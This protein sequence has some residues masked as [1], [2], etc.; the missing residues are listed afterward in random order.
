MKPKLC[1]ETT[2]PS[3]LTSRPSR[4]LIVAGHQQITREWW[5]RQ[6]DEF[7]I[8]LSQL[9]MDEASAGDAEAARERWNAISDFPLLDIPQEVEALATIILASGRATL[10]G[11]AV[12]G[13]RFCELLERRPAPG[14]ARVPRAKVCMAT[15]RGLATG[16]CRH[17]EISMGCGSAE[18]GHYAISDSHRNRRAGRAR[19]Q[20]SWRAATAPTEPSGMRCA[21]QAKATA[22][23]RGR[24]LRQKL[25]PML[26]ILRLP[27]F[28]G[29]NS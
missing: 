19:S 13:S 28:M 26:P 18:P 3:Y 15:H 24:L 6:R 14:T 17:R 27:P 8:Y 20:G 22:S 25:E 4:D 11:S 16:S 21:G 12:P 9:V 29:S 2:I 5:N 23:S 10:K 1:L 7:D